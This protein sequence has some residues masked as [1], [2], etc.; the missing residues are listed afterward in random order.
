MAAHLGRVCEL[1]G[2]PPSC[3]PCCGFPTI[4]DKCIGI[5]GSGASNVPLYQFL[6]VTFS[7]ITNDSCSSC[8]DYN[9][10]YVLEYNN[11]ACTW[12]VLASNWADVCIT[13]SPKGTGPLITIEDDGFG[14]YEYH[15]F[16]YEDD[17]FGQIEVFHYVSDPI[18]APD[19][20]G[21]SGS[22]TLTFDSGNYCATHPST[23]TMEP[24]AGPQSVP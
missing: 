23:I 1:M 5:C 6:T 15:F 22:I 20:C 3:S 19:D 18:T 17:S 7:G 9:G 24:H 13:Q 10:Q 16:M 11:D 12:G 2:R 8:D 14:N 4:E 21:F